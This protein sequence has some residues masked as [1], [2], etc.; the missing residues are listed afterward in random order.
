MAGLEFA[1]AAELAARVAAA[2]GREASY[3][4]GEAAHSP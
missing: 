3:G 1:S 2:L 4:Q